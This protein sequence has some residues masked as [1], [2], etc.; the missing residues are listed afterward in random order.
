MSALRRI[1]LTPLPKLALS[2]M[3]RLLTSVPLPRWL[4][5]SVYR[6]F[7]RSYGVNFDEV[8]GAPSDYRTFRDFFLRPLADGVRPIADGPLVWPCDGR[9]VTSG[10]IS[11]GRIEQLKGVDYSIAELLSDDAFARDLDGGTQATIYL[12][13][14]DY[15][16]VHVPFDAELLGSVRVPGGLFPVNPPTVRSIPNLFA[17][18]ER[19][20]FRFRLPEG[21]PAAVVMVAALN[22]S[23][24]R[25]VPTAPC[26]LTRG[27]ELGHFGFGS[28]TVVL[29]GKQGPSIP[30]LPGD[31]PV[32]LGAAIV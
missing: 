30:S 14:K 8:A 4:R 1:V 13:P 27:D 6:T 5:G 11:G 26:R 9:I 28:T 16:R 7:G 17:R 15:H 12:S 3:M 25:A 32:R 29:V 23:D 10:P 21:D 31:S 24:I 18:N 20:V 19:M 22:V 2:R